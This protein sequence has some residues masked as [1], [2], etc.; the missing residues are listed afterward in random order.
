MLCTK[1]TDHLNNEI[2]FQTVRIDLRLFSS[3]VVSN[4]CEFERTVSSEVNNL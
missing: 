4:K 2:N 3:G 1:D